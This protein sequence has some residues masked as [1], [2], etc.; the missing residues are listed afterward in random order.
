MNEQYNSNGQFPPAGQSPYANQRG[1]IPP[2]PERP[3]QNQYGHPCPQPYNRYGD[4]A[5]NLFDDHR[6]YEGGLPVC[7]P[8]CGY[9]AVSRFCGRCG[10]DLSTVYT[11]SDSH[12]GQVYVVNYGVPNT[13]ASYIPSS[14]AGYSSI[15]SG[16]GPETEQSFASMPTPPSI[17]IT[18][19]AYAHKRHSAKRTAL[20]ICGL[21]LLF[22][23]CLLYTSQDEI[24][25]WEDRP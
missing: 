22:I 23:V 24:G 17:P 7:C 20:W 16:Y 2:P 10:L 6:P 14:G 13:Q 5:P 19:L 12:P 3:L 11:V 8:K 15:P 25:I 4:G 1:I 9:T 18:P 21:C